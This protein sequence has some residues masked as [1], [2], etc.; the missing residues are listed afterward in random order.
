MAL[1]AGAYTATWNSLAMGQAEN[2]YTTSHSAAIEQITGDTYA[3]TAQDGV[4]RGVPDFDISW[5]AIDFSSAGIQTAFW[6][7]SATIYTLGVPGRLAVGSALAKALVLT[8]VAGTTAATVPATL[9]F[10]YA[11][12]KEGFPVELLYA[13]SL[14]YVPLR[15]RIYPNSGVFA[16]IT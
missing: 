7:W 8:A 13:P 5:R 2:G 1:I 3:E 16:T 10:T 14:R 11:I 15:M 12:L 9:T 4:Y 6:P